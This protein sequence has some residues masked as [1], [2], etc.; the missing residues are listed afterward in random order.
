M[1]NGEIQTTIP[2][3]Q[4]DGRNIWSES[5]YRRRR[6]LLSTGGH[7]KGKNAGENPP[8]IICLDEYYSRSW[9]YIADREGLIIVAFEY[10]RNY[11]LPNNEEG[12]GALGFGSKPDES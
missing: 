9:Q 4:R 10:H 8:L 6:I 2:M 12:M 11:R 7:T 5:E 1:R 3:K